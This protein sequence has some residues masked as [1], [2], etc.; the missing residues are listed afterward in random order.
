MGLEFLGPFSLALNIAVKIECKTLFDITRTDVHS[1]RN[2][3]DSEDKTVDIFKK[4]H[5]QS[6]FDTIIQLISMRSQPEDISYPEKNMMSITSEW[7][8]DYHSKSKKPMWIFTFEV[9]QEMVFNDGENMFGHLYSD[10]NGV[11]MI[12]GLEEYDKIVGQL[13]TDNKKRNIIF[14]KIS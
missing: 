9:E 11:P 6:N 10:C 3:L 1:R 5:Q 13:S 8:T 14:K 7:G 4:R 2:R 12:I